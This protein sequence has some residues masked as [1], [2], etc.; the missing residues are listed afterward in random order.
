M[1]L[2]PRFS[3]P[4]RRDLRRMLAQVARDLSAAR[5]RPGADPLK[6]QYDDLVLALHGTGR[7]EMGLALVFLGLLATQGRQGEALDILMGMV[8]ATD[9]DHAGDRP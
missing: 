4:E 1:S 8:A 7:V 3:R 6:R 9:M 2:L 5:A